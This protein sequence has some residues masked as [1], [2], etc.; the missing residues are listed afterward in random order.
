V[1]ASALLVGVNHTLLRSPAVASWQVARAVHA[2]QTRGCNGPLDA[3]TLGRCVWQADAARGRIA[4]VGDSQAGQYTE[5]VVRAARRAGYETLVVKLNSCP[6]AGVKANGTATPE[7]TCAR[8]NA[9]TLTALTEMRPSIVLLASRSDY[10]VGDPGVS[11]Q[12][13]GGA[14]STRDSGVKAQLWRRGLATVI[15]R[16]NA[17]GTHVVVIHPIPKLPAAPHGC[18]VLTILIKACSGSVDRAFADGERRLAVAAERAA[19]AGAANATAFGFDDELCDVSLCSGA[20][21]GTWTYRDINH[22]TVAGSLLLTERFAGILRQ[23]ER[24]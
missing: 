8:F 4:L 10:Y 2:D 21:A 20:H 3:Q 13:A 17:V 5:P 7:E 14:R 16:L 11:L 24:S 9:G 6:F 19:V 23:A 1:G 12:L 15:E 22:L 18:A